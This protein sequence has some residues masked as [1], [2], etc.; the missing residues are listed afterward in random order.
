MT[1]ASP[2]S[3]G[4]FAYGQAQPKS[5]DSQQGPLATPAQLASARQ[6]SAPAMSQQFGSSQAKGDYSAYSPGGSYQQYSQPSGYPQ[7]GHMNYAQPRSYSPS[8]G[9]SQQPFQPGS[10]GQYV[11]PNGVTRNR[12]SPPPPTYGEGIGGSPVFAVFQDRDGDGVDDKYQTGPGQPLQRPSPDP[13]RVIVRGPEGTQRQ[14]DDMKRRGTWD[15]PRNANARRRLEQELQDIS[16]A[17]PGYYKTPDG[18]YE[19]NWIAHLY[20]GGQPPQQ[21]ARP[22]YGTP[23]AN[24]PGFPSDGRQLPAYQPPPAARPYIGTQESNYPGVPSG[25]QQQVTA[26]QQPPQNYPQS[27]SFYMPTQSAANAMPDYS[28]RDA[29]IASIN[30]SLGRQMSFGT[31]TPQPPQLNFPELWQQAGGMVRNGWSNPLAGLFS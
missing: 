4:R 9:G 17:P 30:D 10:P 24:Y 29:F 27:Q 2:Y 15:D 3:R 16:G 7:G 12:L 25:G 26:Y 18:R 21:S 5:S 22:Y 14:I 13:G 23:E 6:S 20:G 1:I 11:D 19:P 8:G 28:Q 31:P